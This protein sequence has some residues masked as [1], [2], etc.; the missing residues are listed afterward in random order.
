MWLTVVGCSGSAPGP[1][2]PASCYLVEADGYRIVLDLGNGALGPLQRYLRPDRIDAVVLS[3]LHADH[4][5]DMV[6]LTVAL[7][8]GGHRPPRPI[9]VLAAPDAPA[10]LAAANDP[11]AG[12]DLLHGLFA[13]RPV[14][15]AD[16]GPVRVRFAPVTHPVPAVAVRLEHAG[17]SMT[18]SGDTGPDEALIEL[19]AGSD[20]LLCEA[21]WAGCAEQMP[22]L[23][24]TGAEAGRVAARA[25][26]GRLVVTHVPPW[27][28]V[29][30]AVDAA[31]STFDG[32]V[33][34][35]RAG[36]VHDV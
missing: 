26:V 20:V 17:R 19:A 27:E 18:Y 36:Q 13:F 25:G 23:H 29:Q 16:L 35:A 21:S 4:C 1:D 22:G 12:P 7:R 28:S 9:P 31:R 10:R 3:H 6:A 24:L 11:A 5:L 34:A 15:D 33:V 30:G 8:Y 2:S 32:V 14:A